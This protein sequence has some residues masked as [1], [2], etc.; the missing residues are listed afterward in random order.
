MDRAGWHCTERHQTVFLWRQSPSATRCGVG[1]AVALT[2]RTA[3]NPTVRTPVQD[4][5]SFV[6]VAEYEINRARHILST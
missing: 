4:L 2:F 5:V 3:R 1:P 6:L